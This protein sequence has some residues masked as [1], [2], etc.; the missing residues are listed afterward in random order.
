MLQTHKRYLLVSRRSNSKSEDSFI[1]FLPRKLTST[2]K[3]SLLFLVC[4]GLEIVCFLLSF[5]D[6]IL[7]FVFETDMGGNN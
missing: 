1:S 2:N 6:E 4:F 5:L 7:G 3:Y